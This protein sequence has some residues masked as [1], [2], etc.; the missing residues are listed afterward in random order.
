[1]KFGWERPQEDEF[2]LCLLGAG[3]PYEMIA[4]PNRPP[5]GQEFLDLTE[6]SPRRLRRWRRTF[7]TLLRTITFR[8]RKRLVL[9][10]PPH[11]ARIAV[12]REMFPDALFIHIV[13][14]PYVVFPSTVN[15]WR[16]LFETH[17]L[18]KPT[19]AGLE[20]FVLATYLRMHARLEEGKRLLEP[21]QFFELRYED[22]TQRPAAVMRQLYDHLRLGGFDAYLPRLEAYLASVKNYETNRYQLTPAERA[23]VTQRWGPII[24][25]YGYGEAER[26]DADRL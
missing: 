11:T 17:G 22:L 8:T 23:A 6:V 16:R 25:A 15:L 4:F 3:S 2:A 9:K 13:R 12:L 14:D 19:G 5:Q 18:Q 1:M 24:R 20:E 10:S 21:H 7:K 26:L